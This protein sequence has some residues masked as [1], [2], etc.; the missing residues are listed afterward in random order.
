MKPNQLSE[1]EED[2]VYAALDEDPG[3][4]GRY[5]L[6]LILVLLSAALAWA[7]Y[8]ELDEVATANGKVIHTSRGQVVQVLE[9]GILRELN[10]KEGD[11]VTKGQVL[12]QLDDTRAGPAYRESLKKW[13]ALLARASRL[14]AEAYDI[15]LAF[16]PEVQDDP[17]LVKIETNALRARRGAL[18]EQLAALE[19]Q[20][21]ALA[22]EVQLTEPLVKRGVVS[23]VE[24]LRLKRQVAELQGQ[25]AQLRT[26]YLSRASDEL[27]QVDAELGQISEGIVGHREALARTTVYSPTDGVVKDVS[28]TTLGAVINSGQVI[29]E[30]VPVDDDLMVE[31]FM[32]PTEVAYVS[33]GQ[34]AKVKLSAYDDRRYGNLDGMVELVSPDVVMEDAKGG[35][36]SSDATPVNFEPGYY[37][38]LVRITNPGVERNGMKLIP[39]AGMTATVDILTGNKTVLE[40]VLKPVQALKDALRE[41]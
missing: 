28:V 31:A 36:S 32:P 12:L 27:V 8:F 29:M 5:V 17:E 10:V 11:R 30:I 33:V 9:S 23:E 26:S 20:R 18:S 22:R 13:Q 35:G 1:Q 21:V 16:P 19:D 7:A 38:I 15:P 37:K 2:F 4:W 6:Y 34:F 40:Y 24:L 3:R 39:K 14:R 25:K 41:R